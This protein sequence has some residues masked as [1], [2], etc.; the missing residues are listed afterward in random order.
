MSFF[1]N[2]LN[3]EERFMLGFCFTARLATFNPNSEGW[4]LRYM[5]SRSRWQTIV[6]NLD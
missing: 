5:Q 6:S 4:N 3:I 1:S 2:C